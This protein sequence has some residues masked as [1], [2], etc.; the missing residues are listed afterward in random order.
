MDAC[1]G[2]ILFQLFEEK[3]DR[4]LAINK[5]E[6]SLSITMYLV[7]LE[8]SLWFLE[9]LLHILASVACIDRHSNI[10]KISRDVFD[11]GVAACLIQDVFIR[12]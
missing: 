8:D 10:K 9:D 11:K 4:P 5:M 6:I 1:L 7:N 2:Q 3:H 12:C